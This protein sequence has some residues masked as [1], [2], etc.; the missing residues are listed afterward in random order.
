MDLISIIAWVEKLGQWIVVPLLS[1]LA[2]AFLVTWFQERRRVW[3]E[4]LAEIKVDVFRP[5]REKFEQ[6][7]LPLLQG[8]LGPVVVEHVLMP[9]EGSVTQSGTTWTWRLAPRR[10]RGQQSLP[11][12]EAH[13]P[14]RELNPELYDDAKRHHYGGSIRRLEAFEA[15]VDRYTARWLNYA[16]HLSQA[17][18]ERAGLPP[19]KWDSANIDPSWVD[20]N[21]L[22]VFVLERQLGVNPHPLFSGADRSTI[23]ISGQTVA[24]AQSEEEIR[25]IYA[26]LDDL[27]H[28][29]LT[30]GDLRRGAKPL[31]QQAGLLLHEIKQ[32]LLSSKLRGKCPL[33]KV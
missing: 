25:P 18:V 19:V 9:V 11:R 15:E 14:E 8:K 13:S 3:R 32:L 33:A 10:T 7:Y 22:A 28:D 24:R 21:G 31:E 20:A 2:G 26:L 23:T 16:D 4:H 17:I 1:A 30:V 29:R 6:F 27:S 5:L 12:F